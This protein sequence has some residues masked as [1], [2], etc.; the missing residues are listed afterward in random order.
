MPS[1]SVQARGARFFSAAM[2]S[3]LRPPS[4]L[5]IHVVAPGPS[6]ASRA[7]AA[8]ASSAAGASAAIFELKTAAARC[9][10][11]GPT[12]DGAHRA[13]PHSTYNAL[14]QWWPVPSRPATKTKGIRPST[15]RPRPST[16]AKRSA[17]IDS[18]G[19]TTR[20]TARHPLATAVVEP[21]VD[22]IDCGG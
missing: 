16:G 4:A 3:S 17:A 13:S 5:R 21:G 14:Y 20:R 12:S 9:Q 15:L 18:R 11:R 2:A 7:A 19:D 22:R 6:P 8:A 10:A 1:P